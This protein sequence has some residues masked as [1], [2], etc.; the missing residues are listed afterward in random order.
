MSIPPIAD[1]FGVAAGTPINVNIGVLSRKR[2]R[3]N[4]LESG[5]LF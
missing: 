1:S 5:N 3:R 2:E 4:G